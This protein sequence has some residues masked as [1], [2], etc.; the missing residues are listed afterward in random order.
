MNADVCLAHDAVLLY[1]VGLCANCC[2]CMGTTA[3]PEIKQ[4]AMHFEKIF[5]IFRISISIFFISYSAVK[6]VVV[7][8]GGG[9]GVRRKTRK[10]NCFLVRD[11]SSSSYC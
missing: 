4:S 1:V 9:G 2:Y 11:S 3:V 5:L 10:R 6:V 7:L 8:G